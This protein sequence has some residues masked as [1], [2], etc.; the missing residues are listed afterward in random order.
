MQ[1]F[2]LPV[3]AVSV[4]ILLQRVRIMPVLQEQLTFRD[5][6]RVGVTFVVSANLFNA[7]R[8]KTS[9]SFR[10]LVVSLLACGHNVFP[11]A[12]LRAL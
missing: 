8:D 11:V 4:L 1:V 3:L 6:A 2:Y 9:L 10:A 7:I 12:D 5:L